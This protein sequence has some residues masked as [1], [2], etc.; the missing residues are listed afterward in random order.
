MKKTGFVAACISVLL[1]ACTLITTSM[2]N[3]IMPK[4]GYI[5]Y[6]AADAG[7]YLAEWYVMD[8]ALPNIIA[9]VMIIVGVLFGMYCFITDRR[10]K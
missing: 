7:S 10:V 3:A 4:I 9:I 5:A 8:F 2:L 1:G 6:Q